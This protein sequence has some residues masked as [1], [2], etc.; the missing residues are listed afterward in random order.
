MRPNDPYYSWQWHLTLIGDIEQVWNEYTG[1][2]V[3][4]GVYDTGI[5]ISHPDLVAAYD[6]SNGIIYDGIAY[7]G[8]VLGSNA[9][10][11]AVAGLI[12]A[13]ANNGIGGVGVAFGSRI[14]GV[15]VIDDGSPLR[16]FGFQEAMLQ[17]TRYDVVNNSWNY[18]GSGLYRKTIMPNYY[19]DAVV[20]GR[21]GLGT[22]IVQAAGNDYGTSE[23]SA[24]NTWRQ[25]IVVGGTLERGNRSPYANA[26]ANLLICAPASDIPGSIATTDIT[27]NAGYSLSDYTAKFNGTS[28]ATPIVTGVVALM[29]EANPSLGWRDVQ[30][31][32]SLS[33]SHTGSA[34]ASGTR[35]ATETSLWNINGANDWNGGGRHFSNDY[36]Y[37]IVNAFNAVRMAEAWHY[38]SSVPQTSTNEAVTAASMP[39]DDIAIPDGGRTTIQLTVSDEIRVEHVQLDLSLTHNHIADLRIS[40]V[41]PD[42]E[43]TIVDNLVYA[44]T[45]K[46]KALDYAYGLANLRGISGAGTWTIEIEDGAANGLSGSISKAGIVIYGQ[47][48]STNS[49]YHYT[50]EFSEV[51]DTAPAPRSTLADTDGGV[52]WIDGSSLQKGI[53][54]DL[55]TRR[56]LIDGI[57]VHIAGIENIMGGDGSDL[58]IGDDT[59]NELRGMRGNDTLSGGGGL[60]T[61]VGGTGDDVYRADMGSLIQEQDEQ[62]FDTVEI[63]QS[64]SLAALISIEVLKVANAA[65]TSDVQLRGNELAQVIEANRGN[66]T[67]DGG[68]GAD[69]MRGLAGNDEYYVDDAADVIEE[70][71]NEGTDRIYS[72][73]SYR[74]PAST[75]IEYMKARPLGQYSGIAL[76]GNIYNQFIEGGSGNDTLDGGGGNDTLRGL[77]GDDIY[78]ADSIGDVIVE[79]ADAGFDTIRSK[80]SFTMQFGQ[81]VE[82]LEVFDRSSMDAINL[83]GNGL[84]Q[85]LF[86][87]N[88]RNTL[89]GRAGADTMAGYGGDDAYLV[90]DSRDVVLEASDAGFDVLTTSVGYTLT[91]GNSIER[92]VAAS[93]TSSIF[94]QGN[95]FSQRIE[96]NAGSNLL[97]GGLGADTLGGGSG[98]DTFRFSTAIGNGNIDH[99]LDFTPTVRGV[100]DLIALSSRIFTSLLP[101]ALS[102]DKFKSINS[103][104]RADSTDMILYDV[105]SGAISYDGDALGLGMSVQ[106]ASV[107]PGIH[108]SAKDFVIYA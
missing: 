91:A 84:D 89:D 107:S 40:L 99:I 6:R 23:M 72:S 34:L 52:D 19:A 1:K 103:G 47:S 58:I 41:A 44:Q 79:G 86:G 82:D 4:V 15:G 81:S 96:G 54:V 24:I 13:S 93:G 30:E 88:G 50:E 8:A 101:G 85:A 105:K 33:A 95:Q 87:N 57:L 61:L 31:I 18:H 22:I 14:T 21:G 48:Q 100:G 66:N 12:A 46:L 10:G 71:Q 77:G 25:A 5:D 80:V 43:R 28:A 32:L 76:Y 53:I 56:A 55:S 2:G 67:L 98:S 104:V 49:V 64:Y 7:D 92:L 27:G 9:H 94:L 36:G 68:G 83:T 42:G 45:L 106:F 90:D 97:D 69:T 73:T 65:S 11:T 75:S 63:S 39:D 37:G 29:L 108:L 51:I 26:G 16:T 102:A 70:Q 35:S 59:A 38:F 62:G 17:L 3:R 78:I 74:L 20:T 60:D